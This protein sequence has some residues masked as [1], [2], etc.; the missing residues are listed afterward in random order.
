MYVHIT[1]VMNWQG[2]NSEEEAEKC[3]TERRKN[4]SIIKQLNHVELEKNVQV[5]QVRTA[6]SKTATRS[7]DW[8]RFSIQTEGRRNAVKI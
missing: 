2:L 4:P 3:R 7:I 1:I 6:Q 5:F 8:A